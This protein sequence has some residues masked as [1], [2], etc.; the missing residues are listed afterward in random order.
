MKT[1]YTERDIVDLHAAGITE[2]EVDDEV[3]LTDL[4]REK[5]LALEMRLKPVARRNSP[6]P[7]SKPPAPVPP[8]ATPA[9]SHP[10][11]V[12][13]LTETE[14]IAHIKAGVIARLGTTQYNG[15]LDQIIPQIL[16]GLKQQQ[17]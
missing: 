13:Q 7:A 8:G 12:A 1:F 9:P 15:L 6:A 17:Y 16:A 11:N 4:A 14:L 3:M 10:V 2:L 5:A